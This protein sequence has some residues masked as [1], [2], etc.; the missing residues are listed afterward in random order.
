MKAIEGFPGYF[1]DTKGN[2]YSQW[3]RGHQIVHTD[4]KP[5]ML[6]AVICGYGYRLITL[7]KDGKHYQRRIARLVLET[8]VG[9][10]PQGSVARH[11]KNG[12][13]DDSLSNLT[14]GTQRENMHDKRRDGTMVEGTKQWKAKLSPHK[15][16]SIRM[17]SKA[18]M[19]RRTLAK[20]YKVHPD[21]IRDV[22]NNRIWK[23][24]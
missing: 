23:N 5:R 14:W 21:T 7:V 15:V 24:I 8:F 11:G 13:K 22:L 20:K 12:Q 4:K 17:F 16:R 1:A 9:P 2:I 6:K 19:D 10:A 18:G 3:A